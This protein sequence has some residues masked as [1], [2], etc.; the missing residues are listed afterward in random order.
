MMK[1]ILIPCLLLLALT[2]CRHG[3]EA[4][5]FFVAGHTYG[6]PSAGNPGMHPPFVNELKQLSSD[7]RI[8]LGILTGDIVRKPDTLSWD[9]VD[10][11][12][13]V[14]QVPVY[15]SPGNH[16]TYNRPLYES[17]YGKTYFSFMQGSDLFIILDGNLDNWNISGDQ[18]VFLEDQINDLVAGTE[19]I[20][21]FVHQLIYWDEHNIFAGVNLNWP[22]YTPDTTNYWGMVE[23]MLQ[24][25]G[26]P[27]CIFS[28]DLGANNRAT[29]V[30]YYADRNI[31]YIASGMGNIE[32]DNYILVHRHGD[33]NLTFELVALGGEPGRL[34]ALENY[35]IAAN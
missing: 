21:V 29:A 12:L 31:T 6:S 17:R 26:A 18:L 25:A 9:S 14:L 35:N 10:A 34:G 24:G 7:E 22:P 27:V 33:G 11:Q 23:P 20:F 19:N 28:G 4:Y 3:G 16:D 5:S 13:S 1:K 2:S 15:F 30:M 32:N 8:A